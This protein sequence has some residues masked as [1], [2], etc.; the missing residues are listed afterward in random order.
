MGGSSG[1]QRWRQREKETAGRAS[2]RPQ[3]ALRGMRQGR[4]E[5]RHAGGARGTSTGAA[6][7]HTPIVHELNSPPLAG[8]ED[9]CSS[10][11]PLCLPAQTSEDPSVPGG[12]CFVGSSP[13]LGRGRH[14]AGLGLCRGRRAPGGGW[15]TLSL[16]MRGALQGRTLTLGSR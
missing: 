10:C 5:A 7:A 1:T 6:H 13:V 3:R 4:G 9:G 16:G 12:H 15:I 14:L 8:G 2:G 11:H